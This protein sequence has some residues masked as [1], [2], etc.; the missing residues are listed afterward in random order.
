MRSRPWS[1]NCRLAPSYQVLGDFGLALKP[2]QARLLVHARY[3]LTRGQALAH[4]R[5]DL[6]GKTPCSR[7]VK[8]LVAGPGFTFDS[9]VRGV[10]D[11]WQLYAV[12]PAK[13]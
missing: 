3:L 5:D 1:V 13:H 12:Q 11:R 4:D 2:R 10:A 6:A 8:D 9:R 7:T